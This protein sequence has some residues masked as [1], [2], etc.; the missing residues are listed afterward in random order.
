MRGL[1][2]SL[3][4]ESLIWEVWN[5]PDVREFWD[6]GRQRFLR[7]YALSERIL[8]EELGPGAVIGGPSIS[9]YSRSWLSSFLRFCERAG[10]RPDFLS[11]HELLPP[12]SRSAR[13]RS[14]F[15]TPAATSQ[16]GCSST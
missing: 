13:S 5:E 10:C 8:R 6:G 3:R 1:A 9:R 4:R 16:L 12:T 15:A 7:H 14:T 11:W 2:R